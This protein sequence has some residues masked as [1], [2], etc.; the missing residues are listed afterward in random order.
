L[1]NHYLWLFR[2][3]VMRVFAGVHSAEGVGAF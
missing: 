1:E 3:L 2:S